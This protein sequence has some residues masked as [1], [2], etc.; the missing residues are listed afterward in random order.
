MSDR[1]LPNVDPVLAI[2]MKELDLLI[3]QEERETLLVKIA[4][5]RGRGLTKLVDSN[6]SNIRT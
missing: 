1:A 3:N 2:K 5:Y 6:S 4:S